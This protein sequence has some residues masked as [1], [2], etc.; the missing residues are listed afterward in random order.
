MLLINRR[1]AGWMILLSFLV[2]VVQA[3]HRPGVAPKLYG[4]CIDLPEDPD[5]SISSQAELL[6]E[7][8]FDGVGYPLWFGDDLDEK[9]AARFSK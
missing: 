4:F 9:L 1:S 2:S 5:P 7:L 8:G 6:H 3:E